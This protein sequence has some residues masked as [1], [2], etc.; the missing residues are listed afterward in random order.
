LKRQHLLDVAAALVGLFAIF[1]SHARDGAEAGY[2]R[3]KR[4]QLRMT[5]QWVDDRERNVGTNVGLHI[6]GHARS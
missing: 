2:L 6:H 1:H 5:R 3:G 4:R